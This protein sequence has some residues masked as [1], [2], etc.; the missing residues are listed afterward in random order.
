V[1]GALMDM[2]ANE[3]NEEDFTNS[4]AC[5]DVDDVDDDDLL[6][7]ELRDLQNAPL[8]GSE[9]GISKSKPITKRHISSRNGHRRTAHLG[10]E[11]TKSK[12]LR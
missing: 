11:V 10:S 12:F 9:A 8:A 4:N 7:E 1:I 6:E 2:E 5:D 3:K